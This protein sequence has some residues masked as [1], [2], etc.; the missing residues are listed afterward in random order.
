MAINYP[1]NLSFSG[2]KNICSNASDIE[3]VTPSHFP[4]INTEFKV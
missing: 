2:L 3:I 1:I 4:I